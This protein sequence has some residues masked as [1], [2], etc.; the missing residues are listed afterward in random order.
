MV[1]SQVL[2]LWTPLPNSFS[3]ENITV[4]SEG[5]TYLA[6]SIGFQQASLNDYRVDLLGAHFYNLTLEIPVS[7]LAGYDGGLLEAG[8]N[9]S[10]PSLF[11][12]IDPNRF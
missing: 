6:N 4:V 2:S 7:T 11:E 8:Q 10:Y 9:V 5:V 3:S 12:G 1:Q